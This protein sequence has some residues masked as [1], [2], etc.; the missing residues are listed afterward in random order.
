MGTGIAEAMDGGGNGLPIGTGIAAATDG[1]G[2]VFMRGTGIAASM[3]GGG[4]GLPIGTGIAA[5]IDGGGRVFMRGTGMAALA[6][7]ADITNEAAA[8]N[9]NVR[10]RVF[11]ICSFLAGGHLATKQLQ[12]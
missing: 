5:A 3:A 12:R 1:G 11:I 10:G 4:N 2:R 6:K 9:L 7:A 8:I